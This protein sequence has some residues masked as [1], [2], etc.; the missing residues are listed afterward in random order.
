MWQVL[1]QRAQSLAQA[2]GVSACGGAQMRLSQRPCTCIV[3]A[4]AQAPLPTLISGAWTWTRTPGRCC[5]ISPRPPSIRTG[6]RR[7]FLGG[8]A[9]CVLETMMTMAMHRWLHRWLCTS[10]T[11]HASQVRTTVARPLKILPALPWRCS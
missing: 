5:P 11:L 1:M 2:G 6:S 4:A 9:R 7:Q 3:V 10:L 8:P